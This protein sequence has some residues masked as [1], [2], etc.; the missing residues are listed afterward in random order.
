MNIENFNKLKRIAS[1]EVIFDPNKLEDIIGGNASMYQRY[2]G[3]YNKELLEL[4]E[5]KIEYDRLYGIS[6]K[7][8]KFKGYDG[9]Q[10]STKT[11]IDSQINTIDEIITLRKKLAIQEIIVDYFQNLLENIKRLSYTTKNWI[12]YKKLQAGMF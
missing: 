5:L 12:D 2:L 11:E 7:E 8:V 9:Y 10:W 1:S 6:L 3:I 4:K